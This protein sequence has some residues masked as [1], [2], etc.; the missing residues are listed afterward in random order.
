MK[1]QAKTILRIFRD[2]VLE[3]VWV[4]VEAKEEEEWEWDD[5]IVSEADNNNNNNERLIKI[6]LVIFRKQF[7]H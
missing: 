6:P 4:L 7:N 3:E 1:I 5:K 2:L